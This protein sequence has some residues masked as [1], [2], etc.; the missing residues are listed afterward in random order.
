MLDADLVHG[1]DL[2][3]IPAGRGLGG[4]GEGE[5]HDK[6][7]QAPRGQARS[8]GR[9]AQ[10][11]RPLFAPGRHGAGVRR[12]AVDRGMEQEAIGTGRAGGATGGDGDQ[13]EQGPAPHERP[14]YGPCRWW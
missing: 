11:A 13:E 1:A 6:G 7:E 2:V 3:A 14:F 5:A 9:R 8:K 4:T 10:Q 12:S